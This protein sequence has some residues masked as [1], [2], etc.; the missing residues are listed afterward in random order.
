LNAEAQRTRRRDAES[1]GKRKR[2]EKRRERDEKA[3]GLR[4]LRP[5]LQVIGNGSIVPRWGAAVLH[6]YMAR[7]E[8]C[9][10]GALINGA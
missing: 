9:D 1:G 8:R 4:G 3:A 10:Y 5:A 6:P 2:K 7:L